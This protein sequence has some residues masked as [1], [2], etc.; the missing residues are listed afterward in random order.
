[1][2]LVFSNDLNTLVESVANILSAE[3]YSSPLAPDWLIVPNQDTGRWLQIE[4][5]DRLGSL[6]NT[7]VTT[8]SEFMWKISDAQP[9]RQLESDLYWA[10]ATVWRQRYP[11]LME[12]EYLQQIS[13]LFEMF[14]HY[15]TERPDWLVDPEKASLL[16]QPSDAWQL[17]LWREIEHLLPAAP[18]QQL[19]GALRDKHTERLDSIARVVVFN[20]DRLSTL[21]LNV[22]KS[23]THNTPCFLCIQSPSPDPWFTQGALE[24]PETH[25]LVADLCREKAKVFS[26]LGDDEPVEGYVQHAT[27][28]ALS[29]LKTHLFQN[30]K[31]PITIDWSVSLVSATSPTQEVVELKRWLI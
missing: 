27:K 23:W 10:I 24:L 3:S 15:L 2:Q 30:K 18:H 31:A 28:S 20:P 8:L 29:E 9:D 11:D 16:I 6:A 22:L 13:T 14:R 12:P 25:P 1:M 17:E 5:T 21:A 19:I 7:K 26:I 4:L